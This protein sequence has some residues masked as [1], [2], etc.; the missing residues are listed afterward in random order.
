M[1]NLTDIKVNDIC[2]R[3]AKRKNLRN[4][5]TQLKI[6]VHVVDAAFTNH[7][8]AISEAAHAVIR[9]WRSESMQPTVAFDK[10]YTALCEAG[11]VF[12]AKH[13]CYVDS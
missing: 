5:A 4:L 7:P 9:T 11:L 13:M 12:I 3:V 6:Y 10:M 8:K 1:R 2:N